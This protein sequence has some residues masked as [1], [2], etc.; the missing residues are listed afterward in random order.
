MLSTFKSQVISLHFPWTLFPETIILNTSYLDASESRI[1]KE[2][3][4]H[5]CKTSLEGNEMYPVPTEHIL[6]FVN[7]PLCI[8]E[9]PEEAVTDAK[10]PLGLSYI[11]ITLVKFQTL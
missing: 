3:Y 8:L 1:K 5:H 2:Y 4:C 9:D 11:Y 7:W 10:V 6:M